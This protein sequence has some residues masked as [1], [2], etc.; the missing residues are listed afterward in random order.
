M[1][2]REVFEACS[3]VVPLSVMNVCG[4]AADNAAATINENGGRFVQG[5]FTDEFITIW[6]N[7][8]AGILNDFECEQE[9]RDW[10]ESVGFRF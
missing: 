10:F 3:N 2:A 7:T 8:V 6:A 9:A 1:K 4:S 5:E